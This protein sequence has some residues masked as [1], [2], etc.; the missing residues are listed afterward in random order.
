MK[1]PLLD[2]YEEW[3][4]RHTTWPPLDIKNRLNEGILIGG[5]LLELGCHKDQQGMDIQHEV[6]NLKKLLHE[7]C[8]MD[9][10]E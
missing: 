10:R 1:E 5:K 6:A 9:R 4:K 8:E 2:Q 7:I 3:K